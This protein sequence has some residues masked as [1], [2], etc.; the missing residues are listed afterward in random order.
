MAWLFGGIALCILLAA[1]AIGFFVAT[2]ASYDDGYTE[3]WNDAH[4][5]ATP[6]DGLPP[7]IRL[8]IDD[9]DEATGHVIRPDSRL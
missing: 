3:G 4:G 6:D 7:A 9:Q 2:A 1:A 8:W 5:K